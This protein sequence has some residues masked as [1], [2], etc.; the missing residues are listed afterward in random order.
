MKFSESLEITPRPSQLETLTELV[1]LTQQILFD[2][3]LTCS[4]C[5]SPSAAEHEDGFSPCN[6]SEGYFG[7]GCSAHPCVCQH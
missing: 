4:V 2:I 1:P 5:V 7:R 3:H 6:P